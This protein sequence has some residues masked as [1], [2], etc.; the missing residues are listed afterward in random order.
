MVIDADGLNILAQHKKALHHLPSKSILTPHPKE[1]ERLIGP[2]ENDFDKIAGLKALA[3]T[4][5]LIVVLK[6]AYTIIADKDTMY[7]NPTGNPGMATAGSGDVL[8]GMISGLMAQGY[9]PLHAA[10][11]GVYI[12][13]LAGDIAAMHTEYEALTAGKLIDFLGN[14]FLALAE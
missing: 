6:D 2:W 11:S 7:I 13:G 12:H 9:P 14:A 3:K 8:T 5:D 1:L 4:H 10:V